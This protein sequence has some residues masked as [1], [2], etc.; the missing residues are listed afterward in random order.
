MVRLLHFDVCP[1]VTAE[2][3]DVN[4]FFYNFRMCV[5]YA[6]YRPASFRAGTIDAGPGQVFPVQ[7]LAASAPVNAMMHRPFSSSS[8]FSVAR[9]AV[10]K[11]VDQA[12]ET[13]RIRGPN[14][15]KV[16]DAVRQGRARHN[17]VD[18]RKSLCLFAPFYEQTLGFL[19]TCEDENMWQH[20]PKEG[21]VLAIVD[22]SCVRRV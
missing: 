19:D 10:A 4:L 20:F 8:Y 1:F 6:P 21:A 17:G 9:S 7:R 5:P 3:V 13:G 12:A 14:I 18:L 16:I 2:T 22:E 15:Q 11:E